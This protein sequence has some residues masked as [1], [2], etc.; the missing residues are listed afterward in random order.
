VVWELRNQAAGEMALE[1]VELQLKR[2]CMVSRVD[3]IDSQRA[4]RAQRS[5]KSRLSY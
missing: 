5:V 1:I 4:W 3:A 2:R